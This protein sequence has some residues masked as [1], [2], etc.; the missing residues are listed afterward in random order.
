MFDWADFLTLAKQLRANSDEASKRSAISRA[1]YAAFGE[2]RIWLENRARIAVP[3]HGRAHDIVWDEFQRRGD[4]NSVHIAQTGRRLK[5][6]RRRADYEQHVKDIGSLVQP[7]L[8]EARQ[9]VTLL[10]SLSP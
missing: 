4:R 9:V 5:D 7:A 6:K 10:E 3:K 1:Y 8:L 2:S